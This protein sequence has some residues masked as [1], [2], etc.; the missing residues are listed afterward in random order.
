MPIWIRGLL[1]FANRIPVLLLLLIA[2]GLT[3]L[4]LQWFSTSLN[5]S[6]TIVCLVIYVAAVLYL[7][8]KIPA[9]LRKTLNKVFK[10]KS[11]ERNK[12]AH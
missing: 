6:Q 11:S 1:F 7:W 5:A 4:A 2:A 12:H 3:A 9:G 10:T 8:K